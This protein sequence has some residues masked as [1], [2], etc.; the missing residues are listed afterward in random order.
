MTPRGLSRR[1]TRGCREAG[2]SAATVMRPTKQWQDD[3]AAWLPGW[4]PGAHI[5]LVL[6]EDLVRQYSLCGDVT[7]NTALQVAVLKEAEGR[8]GSRYVHDTLAEGDTVEVRGPRNHFVLIDAPRYLFIAGG[9]GITPILPVIA[10]AERRGA[11]WRLVY[12]GR[13]RATMAFAGQLAHAHPRQVELCPQDETGIIDLRTWL[14]TPRTDT[15]VYCCSPAP[16]LDAVEQACASWPSGALHVERFAPKERVGTPGASEFTVELARS[17]R[18]LSVPAD[19]SLLDVL[20]EAGVNVLSSCREGTCGTCETAVLAGKPDHRDTL[21]SE[22][23]QAA[24]DVI[25]PCVSRSHSRRLV[26]DL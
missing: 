5:D 10:D 19:R 24:A 23:E 15:A 21:L 22:Q 20:Q 25:F 14:G 12:G 16:L 26:L 13:S 9:I 2:L 7:D 4:H 1:S 8:G 17:D 11:D 6:A 3:H 18:T